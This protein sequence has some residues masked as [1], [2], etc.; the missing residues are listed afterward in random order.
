MFVKFIAHAGMYVEE[1]GFSLLLDPWFFDS[2]PDFPVIEGLG[3]EMWKTIDFQIPKTYEK[4]EEYTPDAI[5]IS[6]F[7]P[8]HSPVRDISLLSQQSLNLGKKIMILHPRI[9]LQK[10]FGIG[11]KVIAGVGRK[12][13]IPGEEITIGPFIIEALEH[14]VP[15]HNAWYIKSATGSLVHIADGRMNRDQESRK[16]DVVWSKLKDLSPTYLFLSSGSHSNKIVL[17]DGTKD[18]FEAG[19]F[20][21]V[22]AVK[23]VATINPRITSLIGIY[24]HSIWRG[25]QEYILPAHLIEDEFE[26]AMWLVYPKTRF[27]RL[28][29]GITLG[30][31]EPDRQKECHIYLEKPINL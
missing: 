12:G 7:H 11:S 25:R 10:D 27:I 6:H 1:E 8:H 19:V 23:V 18:I 29:P 20:T 13:L 3:A 9:E 16:M 26:W 30:V 28:R 4:I 21:P 15:D 22:E 17:Q 24:N 2:T 14:T 31:N 5:L